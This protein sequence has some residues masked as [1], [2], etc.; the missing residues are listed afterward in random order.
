MNETISTL[1]KIIA[2]P[3]VF[4]VVFAQ[5]LKIAPK[6]VA[7]LFRDRPW[8]MLRSIGAVLVVA[9]LVALAILLLFKPSP[10]LT[11]GLAILVSCTPAPL[12]LKGAPKVG[13]GDAAFMAGMH[14]SL[15]LLSFI[16]VPITLD[17]ISMPLGFNAEV[18][19]K[20]M[21]SIIGLT[22]VIPLVL[23]LAIHS[24][25]PRIVEK[26]GSKLDLAGTLLLIIVVLLVLAAFIPNLLEMDPFSYVVI[27]A[28]AASALATGHLL[29]P[30]DPHQKTALAAE[31]GVRHPLLAI[32]IASKNFTPEKALP[33]IVPCVLLF[34]AVALVYLFFRK[35]K[36]GG[37]KPVDAAA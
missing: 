21:E 2:P 19:V 23:G 14:L 25:S 28:V 24:F 16:T 22:I 32:T 7:T 5:G 34:S 26:I 33:V 27:V 17:L 15:A 35:K 36:M 30:Q 4:L 20:S 37:A 10:A 6:Q 8:L 13:K 1:V 11:V 9:P 31:S 3:A 18:D 29:G 12:M